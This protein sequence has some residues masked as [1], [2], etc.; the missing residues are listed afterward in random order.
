MDTVSS[1]PHNTLYV[2]RAHIF[3]SILQ[4]K[5]KDERESFVS[6]YLREMLE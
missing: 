1:G 2:E 3:V 6:G 5:T 4:K